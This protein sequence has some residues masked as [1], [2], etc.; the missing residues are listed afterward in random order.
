MFDTFQKLI[1]NQFE[2][3]LCMLSACI[4]QCPESAWE[5]RIGSYPFSQVA[6]HTLLFADY[7]LGPD[8]ES[9]RRQSFHRD[10]PR[11]FDDYEQLEDREPL[12]RYDRPSINTY[13]EHCRRKASEVITSE[14]ADTLRAPAGFARRNF[15]RSELYVYT[16]RHI[17]HHAAQLG[18]RL[19][20]EADR[21]VPWIG[22]GWSS[23]AVT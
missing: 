21:D 13:M 7:Y 8:D 15:S 3:A 2:A 4:E 23:S 11:F 5:M 9:F 22:S 12:A 14:T 19:R 16:I 18:L 10:N 17:Q 1:A 6:F 20:I